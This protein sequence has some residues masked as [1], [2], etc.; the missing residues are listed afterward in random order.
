[1]STV[2]DIQAPKKATNVSINS[3]LLTRARAL[4]I[5]LSATLEAALAERVRQDQRE[6]WKQENAET[7]AAYNQLVQVHGALGDAFRQF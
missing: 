2:F 5:N 6:R 4:K 1:M 7:I 3:D